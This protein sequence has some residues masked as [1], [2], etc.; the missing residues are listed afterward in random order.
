MVRKCCSLVKMKR[1]GGMFQSKPMMKRLWLIFLWLASQSWEFTMWSLSRCKR[2][3]WLQSGLKCCR[4][5]LRPIIY[6]IISIFHSNRCCRIWKKVVGSEWCFLQTGSRLLL[7]IS[8]LGVRQN[9]QL[10]LRVLCCP[11]QGKKRVC[12][13]CVFSQYS[14]SCNYCISHSVMTE[15]TEPLPGAI[16]PELLLRGIIWGIPL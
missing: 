5:L 16:D 1:N 13:V 14:D 9:K 7:N 2:P 4:M 11:G 10:E 15:C 12:Q 3:L 6:S 8:E